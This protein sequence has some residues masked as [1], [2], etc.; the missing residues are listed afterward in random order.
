[1]KGKEK[2]KKTMKGKAKN[3]GTG[4]RR[5]GQEVSPSGRE[6]VGPYRKVTSSNT[7]AFLD[8]TI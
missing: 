5:V 8:G 6:G 4:K 2:K 3:V 1:M 7:A